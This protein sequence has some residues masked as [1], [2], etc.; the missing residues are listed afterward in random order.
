MGL[1]CRRY[2]EIVLL[3]PATLAYFRAKA[4][5]REF[6]Y[7]YFDVLEDT[8]DQCNLYRKPNV[9]F[10]MD[11]TGLPLDPKPLKKPIHGKKNLQ[12]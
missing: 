7:Q 10:T 9:V 12:Y 1:F 3:T 5:S 11:E 4:S 8:L 2:F 6:I